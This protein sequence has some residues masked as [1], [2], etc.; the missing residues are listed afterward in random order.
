MI[1]GVF[2]WDRNNLTKIRA[3]RI[4]VDE[5][6]Q[7]LSRDP[8]LIYEQDAGGEPRYVYYG[9]TERGRRMPGR[10]T[11]TCSDASKGIDAMS[12][13]KE[14][15]TKVP[16]FTDEDHEAKWWA[17]AKGRA[18]LKQHAATGAPKKQKGSP[19]V[20]NL[21]RA[22]SVQIALRL[23]APDLAKAREIAGRKGIG[24]QTLL[25]MLVHEGLRRESR[26]P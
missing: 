9:E 20:A 19:L 22:S 6:E 17:S 11:T 25:K 24:Y 16:K 26:R 5:V 15:P 14:Q 8:V 1:V 12:R 21:G 4:K 2:D 10:S 23:P 7:A 3:H 18:F 13:A